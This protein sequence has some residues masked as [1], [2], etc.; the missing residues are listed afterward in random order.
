MR[1][2]QF[3]W[4]IMHGC[5]AALFWR[6]PPQRWLASANPCTVT[7][8]RDYG[9]RARMA[10]VTLKFVSAVSVTGLLAALAGCSTV[11]GMLPGARAAA[12]TTLPEGFS[13]ATAMTTP[14]AVVPAT[15]ATAVQ[16]APASPGAVTATSQT[17]AGAPI[18]AGTTA[19]TNI[20]R[21]RPRAGS[22]EAGDGLGA[23]DMLSVEVFGIPDLSRNVEVNGAGEIQLPLIGRVQ[24]ENLT[25]DQAARAI[26]DRYRGR[27]VVNPS[28][29]VRVTQRQ[30]RLLSV[31][32][33]V[34]RPGVYP[35]SGPTTLLQGLALGGG[36][37]VLGAAPVVQ[38]LRTE[39]GQDR[40]LSFDVSAIEA[41]T[42]AD[43]WL[44]PG[45]RIIVAN[46]PRQVTVAG[47]VK[48]PGVYPYQGSISLTQA[49]ALGGGQLPSADLRSVNVIRAIDGQDR[50]SNYDLG[51]I[52]SGNVGDPP[53]VAGDRVIVSAINQAV[54]VSGAVTEPTAIDWQEGLTLSRAVA[55]AKGMSPQAAAGRVA[56]LR[57]IDGQLKAA[58]FDMRAINQGKSPDPAMMPNDRIVVG[59]S[60]V[61]VFIR[62][63]APLANVFYLLS[64]TARNR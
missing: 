61:A 20:V 22:P 32:G 46:N 14:A 29:S 51:A 57:M 54:T 50:I 30:A 17:R 1:F 24:V 35:F 47:F 3:Q 9:F 37:N 63:Y 45:D 62:D 39:G 53:I 64:L 36:L 41:G 52:M 44:I 25:P 4:I 56:V 18:L 31:T 58:Q 34:E 8:R 49:V 12:P 13:T 33:A 21:N 7:I 42:V 40:R 23:L 48:E 16:A 38:L 55:E 2:L 59:E 15:Q 26:E 28:V 6:Q 5:L 10:V 43:P 11:S 19:G 27:Y 60:Q